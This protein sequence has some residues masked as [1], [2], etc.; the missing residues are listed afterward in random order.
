[1][2]LWGPLCYNF[3]MRKRFLV[4]LHNSQAPGLAQ[5]CR[6]GLWPGIKH[7]YVHMLKGYTTS[8]NHVQ[9]CPD[10]LKIFK[11]VQATVATCCRKRPQK[12]CVRKTWRAARRTCYGH[13]GLCQG[14]SQASQRHLH[15]K[16]TWRNA[17]LQI[18]N[19]GH[20]FAQQFQRQTARC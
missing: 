6:T 19:S 10:M 20:R 15:N 4:V 13:C 16:V 2:L 7:K 3:V 12:S 14:R 18:H 11:H 17:A 9:D 1:M 8:S 5:R